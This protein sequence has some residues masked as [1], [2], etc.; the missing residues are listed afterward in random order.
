MSLYQLQ[1][2]IRNEIK[3]VVNNIDKLNKMIDKIEIKLNKTW[4]L[5]KLKKEP[6]R[7]RGLRI[8]I[9]AGKRQGMTTLS[10]KI[11]QTLDYSTRT[12]IYIYLPV[13]KV[14]MRYYSPRP[15][16]DNFILHAQH[17]VDIE[18]I[19]KIRHYLDIIFISPLTAKQDRRIYDTFA[20]SLITRDKWLNLIESCN[21]YNFIVIDYRVKLVWRYI[22]QI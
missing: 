15:G 14:P 22:N 18:R 7:E 9:L 11:R 4:T 6:N 12:N 1:E 8:L 10:N 17:R 19:Y 16:E 3:T 13:D 2:F 5:N 20:S 21:W